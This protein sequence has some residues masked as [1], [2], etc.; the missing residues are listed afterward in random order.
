MKM[1][2]FK[3][4]TFLLALLVVIL[5]AFSLSPFIYRSLLTPPD[6][7]FLGTEGFHIGYYNAL[8][9][10]IRGMNGFWDPLKLFSFPLAHFELPLMGWIGGIFSLPVDF[11][12]H[13]FRSIIILALP[14]SA[15]WFFSSIFEKPAER[16]TAFLLAFLVGAFPVFWVKND[17]GR[18]ATEVNFYQPPDF[19]LRLI[20]Y[21]HNLLGATLVL[22]IITIFFKFISSKEAKKS[23]LLI[24]ALLAVLVGLIN[25]PNAVFFGLAVMIFVP[26]LFFFQLKLKTERRDWIK[27]ILFLG[28]ASVAFAGP[29]FYFKWIYTTTA[30]LAVSASAERGFSAIDF[31]EPLLPLAWGYFVSVGPL[32]FLSLFGLKKFWQELDQKRLFIFSYLLAGLLFF[33]L[34]FYLLGTSRLRHHHTPFYIPWAILATYGFFSLSTWLQRRT[35]KLKP[36][37]IH[38]SLFIILIII[39]LPTYANALQREFTRFGTPPNLDPYVYPK[40]EWF[41]A[42]AWLGDNSCW[43]ERVLAGQ[44]ASTIIPAFSGN[45]VYWPNIDELSSPEGQQR[46]VNSKLILGGKVDK[47]ELGLLL[48][49]EK[50]SLI[51]IGV[52]ERGMGVDFSETPDFLHLIFSNDEISI[53]EVGG[54]ISEHPVTGEVLECSIRDIVN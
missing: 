12:Y 36:F 28:I 50:I 40:K 13:F 35:K 24:A 6:N 46:E 11:A 26:L 15:Y 17:W 31:R 27:I 39:S 18:F 54:V 29:L 38:A 33:F 30:Y 10:M 25:V 37:T 3:K 51:F 32:V 9:L 2:F 47:D 14:L 52:E 5:L 7:V 34:G 22:V 49:R 23:Y 4:D 53:Y 44:R 19:L 43:F 48:V 16:L 20:R 8:S 21:P 42:V 41:A 1:D 45:L